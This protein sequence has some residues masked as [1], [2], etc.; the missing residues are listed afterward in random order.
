V[1]IRMLQHRE[2]ANGWLRFGNHDRQ[3]EA[4]KALI[5]IAQL[6]GVRRGCVRVCAVSVALLAIAFFDAG[7]SWAAGLQ[8]GVRLGYA[9][10]NGSPFE[11]ADSFGGTEIIGLQVLLPVAPR[12]T[13]SVEGEGSSADIDFSAVDESADELEEGTVE[14]SD[15]AIYGSLRLGLLPLAGPLD[16][17][18]GGGAGVHFSELTFAD[19]SDAVS[20]ALEEEVGTE[21]SSLEWHGLAGASIPLGGLFAVFAE[22]RYR[23][24]GGEYDRDGW[25]GY[26]GL[27][28]VL[29]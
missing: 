21:D 6:G 13:L 19:V 4:R 2:T 3:N 5:S 1:T 26:V 29:K 10:L 27:N 12:I 16:L 23:D 18:V 15:L 11:G 8:L 24:I 28:I 7:D 17:Y 14:W 9:D 20:D 22:G 25:A